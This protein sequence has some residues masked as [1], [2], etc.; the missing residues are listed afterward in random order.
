MYQQYRKFFLPILMVIL[1]VSCSCAFAADETTAEV[2]DMNLEQALNHAYANSRSLQIANKNVEIARAD[3]NK[4]KTGFLPYLTYSAIAINNDTAPEESGTGELDL[5]LPLYT[6]GQLTS[7]ARAAKRSLEIAE[8]AAVQAKQQLT[9]DVKVAFYNVWLA[10]ESVKVAQ[11]SYSNMQ[12]HVEK[13]DR[14]FKTGSVSKY[15]L[16]QAEV[17]REGLK[18]SVIKA[19]NAVKLAKQNLSTIIGYDIKTDYSVSYDS[20]NIVFDER[21]TADFDNLLPIAMENRYEVKQ[22]SLQKELAEINKKLEIAGFKPTVSLDANYTAKGSDYSPSEWNN[23][24]FSLRLVVSGS[25]KASTGYAV[26]SADK[27]VELIEIQQQSLS[28]SISLELQQ[29]L[30]TLIESIETVKANEANIALATES[31]RMVNIRYDS[32]MSTTMDVMDSQLALDTALN[33][34]YQGLNAYLSACAK[35]DLV[36]AK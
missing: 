31:L 14:Q 21:T 33:G 11:S 24:D 22:L 28:D 32:G 12:H 23:D 25:F 19:E 2:T 35:L 26:S 27:S 18:P 10:Q 9:Y 1:I 17:Q 6:G 34:Y 15:D 13:V 30:Q 4:A 29:S 20:K 16:L 5:I 8:A 7:A 3:Y 36:L